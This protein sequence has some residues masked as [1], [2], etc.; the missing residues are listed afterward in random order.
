MKKI[1]IS[2]IFFLSVLP[3]IQA[4]DYLINFAASGDTNL[5]GTVKINNLST[6]DTITLNGGDTLH[7]YAPVGIEFPNSEKGT[8][9]VYPNPMTEQSILTFYNPEIAQIN[10]SVVEI[11][12]KTIYQFNSSLSP[13]R[14]SYRIFGINPGIYFVKVTS[15]NF[16]YIT[17]LISQ[18]YSIRKAGIEYVSTI[19][20]PSSKLLKNVGAI[21]EMPYSIGDQ[22]LFKG[23]SGIYSTIIADKPTNNKT[24][25]FGFSACTDVNN[26]NYSIVQ[27]GNQ[28][29]MAENLNVGVRINGIQEQTNNGLIEKY[30]V[31][32]LESNC[33][34]YGG[35]YQW[36]ETM[37]YLTIAG[38]QGI[39][40]I[41]WHIPTNNEW[42][43][44]TTF[45]GG[46]VVA[47]GKMKSTGTIEG[48]TGLWYSPNTG[49][50]NESGF[51]AIPAGYCDVSLGGI[52]SDFGN[53]GLWYSSSEINIFYAWMKYIE[54][55]GGTIKSNGFK[56][57]GLSVRCVHD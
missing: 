27:I 28:T 24:I 46:D 50:S 7:L 41:G 49:A 25:V 35:L 17:K 26:N 20:N 22:L 16:V 51:T 5:V 4:Q 57:Y 45:L 32:D 33:N 2:L 31:N 43:T 54:Y 21:I 23:I 36:D 3:H 48:G 14:Y 29:W 6:G 13:G 42:D 39:C 56:N 37:Q 1:T 15:K 34:I 8:I 55:N 10:I 44:I 9:Q 53:T 47:G 38:V 12:G 11:T 18:N 52:F 40:P 30:C 19:K